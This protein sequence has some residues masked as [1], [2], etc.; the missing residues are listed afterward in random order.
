MAIDDLVAIGYSGNSLGRINS[1]SKR[2]GKEKRLAR[3]IDRV[4]A[5][6]IYNGDNLAL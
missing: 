5:F 3:S 4:F 2:V 1:R 6:G